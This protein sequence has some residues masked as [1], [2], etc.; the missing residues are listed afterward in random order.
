[1]LLY[2]KGFLETLLTFFF[3]YSLCHDPT[4]SGRCQNKTLT[5]NYRNLWS[6]FRLTF[7]EWFV[8]NSSF[9]FQS[10]QSI[11]II[12]WISVRFRYQLASMNPQTF[13]VRDT[14]CEA[15]ANIK[16]VKHFFIDTANRLGS[17]E[18]SWTHE[19]PLIYPPQRVE[20]ILRKNWQGN[21]LQKFIVLKGKFPVQIFPFCIHK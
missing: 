10:C 11:S 6:D 19:N 1:M 9:N 7:V 15:K 12:D 14:R 20:S 13:H 8:I 17:A 16:A 2:K 3:F 5:R 18:R 4:K 21:Y